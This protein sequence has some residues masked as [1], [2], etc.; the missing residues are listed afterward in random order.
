MWVWTTFAY[1]IPVVVITME[2]LSPP[3]KCSNTTVEP[4]WHSI[5]T[6][7]RNDT[8]LEVI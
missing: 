7:P 6:R 5:A 8:E 4:A 3:N 2:I 1:L